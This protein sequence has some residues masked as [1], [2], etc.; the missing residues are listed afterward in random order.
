ML[1]AAGAIAGVLGLLAGIIK[2]LLDKYFKQAA[3]LESVKQSYQQKAID[4]LNL[5]IVEHKKELK[6]LAL[7]LE[8][9]TRTN[10]I[11]QNKLQS[12]SDDLRS[13]IGSVEKSL[14][15]LQG[16]V[17]KLSDELIIVKGRSNEQRTGHK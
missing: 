4:E 2:M 15:A 3:E 8:E 7:K 14:E 11:T 9:N 10:Q 5:A 17:V 6:A 16:H 1:E 13:Y 12:V